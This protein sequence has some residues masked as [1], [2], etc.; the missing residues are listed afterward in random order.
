MAS[1]GKVTKESDN[2]PLQILCLLVE[3]QD[4]TQHL[5]LYLLAACF[6]ILLEIINA[7]HSRADRSNVLVL[8]RSQGAV[9]LRRT[10]NFF[11]WYIPV[12]D[13]EKQ[14]QAAQLDPDWI[15]ESSHE[16]GSADSETQDELISVPPSFVSSLH[17]LF[18]ARFV[19]V[20]VSCCCPDPSYELPY[21]EGRYAVPSVPE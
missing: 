5:L 19:A 18:A 9:L 2:P 10:T 3:E 8:H 17:T 6:G 13:V 11:F 15:C 21:A 14:M 4:A 20:S 7:I 16:R 12:L 1:I